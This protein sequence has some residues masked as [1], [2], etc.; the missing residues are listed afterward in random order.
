MIGIGLT[1][2]QAC[3]AVLVGASLASLNGFMAGQCGRVH[4][5]GYEIFLVRLL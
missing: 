3:G 1:A 5:L 4:H 2:G